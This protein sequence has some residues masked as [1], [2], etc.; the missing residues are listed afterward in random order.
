MLDNDRYTKK[1][2]KRFTLLM[3]K[4]LFEKCAK[5]HRRSVAKE[6]ETAFEMHPGLCR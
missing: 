5:L 3:D 2:D 6:I 1:A 4:K